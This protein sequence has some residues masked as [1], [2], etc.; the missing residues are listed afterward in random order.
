MPYPVPVQVVVPATATPTIT[1]TFTVSPTSTNTPNGTF[2]TTPTGTPSRTATQTGTPTMTPTDVVVWCANCTPPPTQI[3]LATPGGAVVVSNLTPQFTQLP[4]ATALPTLTPTNTP[5]NTATATQTWTPSNTNTPILQPTATAQ[6]VVPVSAAQ[7]G[8]WVVNSNVG[9]WFTALPTLTPTNTPTN[10]PA[11]T[12]YVG[13]WPATPTN[14]PT[15]TLTLTPTNT[16]T[17][18]AV[19]TQTPYGNASAAYSTNTAATNNAF[20]IKSTGARMY[21]VLLQN[22]SATTGL[23]VY[24][25]NVVAQ[26]TPGT[27][28][29]YKYVTAGEYF[30]TTTAGTAWWDAEPNGTTF[31]AGVWCTICAGPASPTG[32]CTPTTANQGH[33]DV[34]YQ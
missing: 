30:V 21:N 4:Y 12:V 28:V 22:S 33:L 26:P 27:S 7:T 6:G 15:P 23:T 1:P 25:Y 31:S 34:I 8:T 17:A 14:I 3:P 20:Q 10:T 32:A 13:N 18:T 16:P 19:P 24:F 9:T 5:T 29:V 11:V 2:T